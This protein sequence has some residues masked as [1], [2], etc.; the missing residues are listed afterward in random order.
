MKIDNTVLIER[1]KR[2]QLEPVFHE[3][4]CG[5]DS[6]HEVLMP[7]MVGEKVILKCPTCGYKQNWIPEMFYHK[8]FDEFYDN[9]LNI[10]RKYQVNIE[11]YEKQ[12]AEET[13]K[14]SE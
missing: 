1:V 7:E 5:E 6:S 10:I 9:Q 12:K 4:T 14:E 11:E 8:D 3:L 2:F 13:Q